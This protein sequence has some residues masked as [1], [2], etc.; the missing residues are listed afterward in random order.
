MGQRGQTISE[1]FR[2]ELSCGVA[3][4]ADLIALLEH[5]QKAFKSIGELAAQ[6]A[7][8]RAHGRSVGVNVQGEEQKLLDALANDVIIRCCED[9]GHLCGIAS[10]EMEDVYQ[11]PHWFS[12]GRYLLVCDPLDGSSNIDVNV[13]IGS[14]FSILLAPDAGEEAT[15]EDF[16]QRGTKQVAAG[17]A[18]YGPAAMIVL[19]V[20]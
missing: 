3:L 9:S 12:R 17:Y 10:E 2:D 1:F 8:D 11:I 5:L 15:A 16:L 19:T 6:G 13:T 18:L 14:I 20:G 4:D 7:L